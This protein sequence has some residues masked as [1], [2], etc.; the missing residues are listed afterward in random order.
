MVA[1]LQTLGRLKVGNVRRA[2]SIA[3][4]YDTLAKTHPE[5]KLEYTHEDV[6]HV[7]RL[8]GER[9]HVISRVIIDWCRRPWLYRGGH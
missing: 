7:R 8:L 2:L 6:G 4:R 3:I 9:R 1:I 5:Y